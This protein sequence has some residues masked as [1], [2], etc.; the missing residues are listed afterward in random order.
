MINKVL[1]AEDHESSN[2]SLQKV[3]EELGIQQIDYVYYCDDA[4][5]QIRQ[6]VDRKQSYD[7]LIT[8][9]HFEEDGQ[10]QQLRG[11]LQ[12]IPAARVLQPELKILVFSAENKPATIQ[13]LFKKF[14]VDGYVRKARSDAKELRLAM[15]SL[16]NNRRYFPRHLRQLLDSKNAF[17]FSSYDI[18]LLKLLADGVRQKDIPA[19]LQEQNIR[20][21]GLSSVEKRLSLLREEHAFA[22]NEQLIGFCKEL[23]I[24]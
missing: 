1:I 22:T 11:G 23:G 10:P 4:L 14:E 8:D 13:Q 18:A 6:A 5:K 15:E 9:L 20:P 7:L 12:L 2:L 24:I 17:E 16:S 21:A 19:C 3:M